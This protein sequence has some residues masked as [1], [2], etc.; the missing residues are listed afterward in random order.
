MADQ[1]VP[2][3]G[4]GEAVAL[5]LWKILRHKYEQDVG[6]TPDAE[7]EFYT[8]CRQAVYGHPTS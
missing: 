6:K 2:D 5:E 7:L 3:A 8:K 4:G 1:N